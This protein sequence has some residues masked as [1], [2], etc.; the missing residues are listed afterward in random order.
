[1]I[2]DAFLLADSLPLCSSSIVSSPIRELNLASDK[3]RTELP[4]HREW[5]LN[6]IEL[7]SDES[8]RRSVAPLPG[9]R[10]LLS[11]FPI[12]RRC[13]K[14]LASIP[15]IVNWERAQFPSKFLAFAKAKIEFLA[16][17]E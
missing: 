6:A 3:V 4:H 7:A 5:I 11:S 2:F 10:R 17:F 9:G 13:P 14:I 8:R 12:C 15:V 16:I 1:L